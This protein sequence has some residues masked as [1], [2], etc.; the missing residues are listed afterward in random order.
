MFAAAL[1]RSVIRSRGETVAW[2]SSGTGSF[3]ARQRQLT[4]ASAL[5]ECSLPIHPSSTPGR[6]AIGQLCRASR[7]LKAVA[8]RL[9]FALQPRVAA[10]GA[11][12][13]ALPP[14]PSGSPARCCEVGSGLDRLA[15]LAMPATCPGP[16]P[17]G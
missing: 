10:I 4:W 5:Q 8:P 9:I 2:P 16:Q 1:R 7:F 17:Q 14:Q 13:A 3:A 15:A 11:A 12:P 6:S